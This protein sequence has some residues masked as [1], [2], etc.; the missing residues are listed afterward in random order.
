MIQFFAVVGA[1][2]GGWIGWA[3]VSRRKGMSGVVAYGGGFVV[4]CVLMIPVLFLAVWL[5]EAKPGSLKASKQ[6]NAAPAVILPDHNYVMRDGMKYGYPAAISRD[7]QNSGQV[8]S[9]LVMAM[10]AGERNGKLQAHL[11]DGNTVSAL[12]CERPCTYLKIMTYIDA[13]YLRDQIRVEHAVSDP[14]S[15]GA[16]IMRDAMN[17]KLDRYGVGRGKKRYGQWVDERKGMMDV[18]LTDGPSWKEV[19]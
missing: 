19:K 5:V 8:S 12:E 14:S 18:E 10:F 13:D 7:Q 16:L 2:L 3:V 1:F 4:G 17:G 6:Q 11:T 15:V 9:A